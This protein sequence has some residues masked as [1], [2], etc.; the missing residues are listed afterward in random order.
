MSGKVID[1][2]RARQDRTPLPVSPDKWPCERKT[3][4]MAASTNGH[5][6]IEFGETARV[7]TINVKRR[8]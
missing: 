1:L 3:Y 5:V 2:V 7:M 8:A 6:Y 4:R